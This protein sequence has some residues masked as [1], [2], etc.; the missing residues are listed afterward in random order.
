MTMKKR[1][2]RSVDWLCEE[3]RIA[4]ADEMEKIDIWYQFGKY[5]Q[6]RKAIKRLRPAQYFAP[7]LKEALDSLEERI[8][9]DTGTDNSTRAE[10]KDQG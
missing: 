6:V 9:G 1:S 5:D 3:L 10:A 7:E 2:G 4:I 8:N